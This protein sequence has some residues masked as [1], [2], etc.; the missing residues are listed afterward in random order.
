MAYPIKF[1]HNDMQGAPTLDGG[2]GSV[3]ALLDACLLNGFNLITLDSLTWNGSE[4]VATYASGH[5]FEVDQVVNIAGANETA[6]NGEQRVTWVDS[7]SFKFAPDTTPSGDA[8]GTITAEA[9][10]IGTWTKA[11]DDGQGTKAAYQS[12]DPQATAQLLRVDDSDTKSGWNDGG[13]GAKRTWVEGVEGMTDIN[14]FSGSF[15]GG[16]WGKVFGYGDFV[17]TTEPGQWF[18]IGDGRLFYFFPCIAWGPVPAGF[19]YGDIP[20]VRAG[21]AYNTVL[22]TGSNPNSSFSQYSDENW[23]DFADLKSTWNKN[24]AR[25]WTQMPGGVSISMFGSGISDFLGASGL[26]FP[27]PDNSGLYI[28]ANISVVDEGLRGSMPGL[29]QIMHD[30]P[31][32]DRDRIRNI[33]DY[34]G[35]TFINVA[36]TKEK[37]N[38]NNIIQAAAVFDLTG[39][40]R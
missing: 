29:Y 7:T 22:I 24:I 37:E 12:T 35:K 13:G 10:P 39:P 18:L 40:W 16:W 31:L 32:A 36:V 8:T 5:G 34:P 33:T 2:T 4:A 26:P 20:S 3:I 14:T 6:Y 27:N 23:S 9:A 11:H 15:G 21:D 28:A 38:V 30:T 1:F 25:Q 17:A 19:V